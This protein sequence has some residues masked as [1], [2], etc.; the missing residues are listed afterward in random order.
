MTTSSTDEARVEDWS[1]VRPTLGA[2]F[3][4]TRIEWAWTLFGLV[5]LVVF[6]VLLLADGSFSIR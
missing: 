1:E 3:S 6:V 2:R 4:V 5:L